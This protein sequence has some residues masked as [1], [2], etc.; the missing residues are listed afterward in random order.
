MIVMKGGYSIAFL[1]IDILDL[2]NAIPRRVW[3]V[4]LVL[5]G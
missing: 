2:G 3:V 1:R 4:G 5:P